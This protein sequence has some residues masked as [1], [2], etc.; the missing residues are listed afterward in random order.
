[1]IKRYRLIIGWAVLA[2]F[3]MRFCVACTTI[4]SST[5]CPAGTIGT[6]WSSQDSNPAGTLIAAGLSAAAATGF[7]ARLGSAPP[8]TTITVSSTYPWGFGSNSGATGCITPSDTPATTTINNN[9]GGVINMP[10]QK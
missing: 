7:M 10:E 2:A 4:K 1:M 6:S 9:Q 3:A 5:V 8:S